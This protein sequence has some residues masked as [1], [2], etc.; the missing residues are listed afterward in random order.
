MGSSWWLLGGIGFLVLELFLPV[1]FYFFLLGCSAMLV[2]GVVA[3]GFLPTLNLQ[4]AAFVVMAILFPFVFAA[5]LKA[6]FPRKVDGSGSDMIGQIVTVQDLIL[7]G[8]IGV[9][10]LWGSPWRIKNIDSSS[11]D[12]GH[13]VVVVSAEGVTLSVKRRDA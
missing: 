11:F 1:G 8:A 5:K 3:I 9:G 7:P 2:G 10:H 12:K 13:E 6:I 4:L